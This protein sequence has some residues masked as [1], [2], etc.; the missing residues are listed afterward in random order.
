MTI[1]SVLVFLCVGLFLISIALDI[2]IKTKQLSNERK[3]TDAINEIIEDYRHK[4][5][6]E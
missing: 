2:Y 4:Q 6:K 5:Q 3:K 1:F